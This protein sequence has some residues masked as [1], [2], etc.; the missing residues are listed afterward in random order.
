MYDRVRLFH[1]DS[2]VCG[3]SAIALQTN[4]PNVLRNEAIKIYS[5]N[6]DIKSS[7][8]IYV[9]RPIGSQVWTHAEKAIAANVSATR[10]WEANGTVFGYNMLRDNKAGEFGH[11]DYYPVVIAA[12]QNK[13]QYNG[14]DALKGMILLD[15]IRGRLAE[16]S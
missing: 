3:A 14:E 13:E 5:V 7:E 11:N 6:R 10:E 16:V 8:S 9:A 1:T 15:E 4:A 12:C 2:I